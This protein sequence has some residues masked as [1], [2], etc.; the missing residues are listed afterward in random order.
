MYREKDL[1]KIRLDL[2]NNILIKHNLPPLNIDLKNRPEYYNSLKAYELNKDL[3][4]GDYVCTPD[5]GE[6]KILELFPQ[7]KLDIYRFE[8]NKI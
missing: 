7:G 6:A 3:K 4:V 1:L 5:G 2:L 8:F